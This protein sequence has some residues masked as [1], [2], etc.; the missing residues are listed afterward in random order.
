[1][2]PTVLVIDDD[3]TIR[4]ILADLL[5]DSGFNVIQAADGKEGCRLAVEAL[6]DVVLVDLMMPEWDGVA[7]C[8][9]LHAHGAFSQTA[10][11]LMTAHQNHEMA[12]NP[13]VLGADDYVTKP[14]DRGE[15]IA[16]IKGSLL[17]KQR[18]K[19]VDAKARNYDAL[20]EI[21]ETV[22]SA[23]DAEM[24]L[25]EIVRKISGHLDAV[26]RCSIALI[27]EHEDCGQVMATTADLLRPT[28]RI[29]LHDY[30]EIQQVMKTGR[31]LLIE[32]VA[33]SPLMTE[34]LPV[35]AGR[36][37]NAILV[38]P[39]IHAQRVAGAMIIRI[40]RPGEEIAKEEVDFCQLI[41]NI[42]VAALKS[43]NFFDL[44]WEEAESLRNAKQ[45]LEEDLRIKEI[46]EELFDKASEGLVA[47]SS[48]EQ[49]VFANQCM[50][51]LV[52]CE[53]SELQGKSLS[54]F[55][56]L[57]IRQFLDSPAVAATDNGYDGRFDLSFV[58][59][60]GKH[61]IFSVSISVVPIRG[62]LRVA[63]FRDVTERRTL[64]DELLEVR[65]TLEKANADLLR[66]DRE[67]TEFLN[68]A[69]HELRIPVAIA[70]G[71]CS[72]LAESDQSLLSS[73]QR[74]Y[75]AQS[76]EAS[77]R[78]SNLIDNLLDLSRIDAGHMDLD[79]QTHDMV[80]T[81]KAFLCD[82]ANLVDK[83]RLQLKT[84]LPKECPAR[85]DDEKIYRVLTN[86]LGNAVK[87]TPPGGEI[88]ISLQCKVD[89][90]ICTIEDSGR[91]IPPENIPRL[92]EPFSQ[93]GK[94]STHKK[95]TGLGLYICRKIVEA[96]EGRIWV[97]SQIG[98]GSSFHFSLPKAV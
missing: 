64:E 42:V 78:L 93:V 73:D 20:L 6:P 36:N 50:L 14:F 74:N 76:I 54:D 91:G 32:D 24:A 86:L 51:D 75:V 96:H 84:R 45:F 38:F 82:N 85:F 43:T 53:R 25:K 88:Q 9:Y 2:K 95:G 8:N 62:N 17:K 98:L 44:V 18:L 5:N 13:F 37:I 55:F 31:P 15:L 94:Q 60:S 92:F 22:R 7:V 90:V 30:P 79:V 69:A 71:Y 26:D 56:G 63:A 35:L 33:S 10:V 3:R 39:V 87:F 19:N 70:N 80:A 52:E 97:E 11:I 21:S 83:N 29:D 47:F 89:N 77:E 46:Y 65:A 41:S 48:S 1:M 28:F 49:I 72:L 34:I 57:D 12:V 27:R 40:A 66:A 4:Q 16:R 67:R 81:V 58:S 23:T 61:R 59:P 68:I